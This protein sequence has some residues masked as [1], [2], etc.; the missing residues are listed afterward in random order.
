MNARRIVTVA[1]AVLS[2]GPLAGW[3]AGAPVSPAPPGPGT[4]CTWGGT[5][6]DPTGSFTISPGLTNNP[7]TEPSRFTVTGDLGGDAGCTGTLTYVGQIDAGGTCAYN[8]FDGAAHGIP[9]VRSFAGVGTGPLGPARL[10]D[11]DGN[12]IASENADVS[13]AANAPHLLDCTTPE[14]FR[15]GNFHSVIVF[16]K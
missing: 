2:L 6:Q 8:F 12:T 15:G 7:S 14:G 3:A 5:A 1:A 9:G 16:V 10:L 13:T 11:R 4:T